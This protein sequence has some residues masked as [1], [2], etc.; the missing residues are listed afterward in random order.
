MVQHAGMMKKNSFKN[1]KRKN[2]NTTKNHIH[3]RY[4]DNNEEETFKWEDK[5]N[6][7]FKLKIVTWEGHDAGSWEVGG[8]GHIL[9]STREVRRVTVAAFLRPAGKVKPILSNFSRSLRPPSLDFA[10][11][12]K[13]KYGD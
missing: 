4:E 7:N 12:E 10:L 6:E 11:K 8:G 2:K 1:Y 9:P 13:K 5:K 3:G